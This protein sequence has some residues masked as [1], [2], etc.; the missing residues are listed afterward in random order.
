MFTD[1]I[2][3][4]GQSNWYLAGKKDTARAT[5]D[6]GKANASGTQRWIYLANNLELHELVLS[7]FSTFSPAY[8]CFIHV[9]IGLQ[10]R[11]RNRSLSKAGPLE[12][13]AWLHALSEA[14]GGK[15]SAPPLL[16]LILTR[17]PCAPPI[18]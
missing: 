4:Q 3:N 9:G 7:T 8:L 12:S 17:L 10:G 5:A 15:A 1:G 18:T 11:T 13:E 14:T 6:Y 2:H 16:L